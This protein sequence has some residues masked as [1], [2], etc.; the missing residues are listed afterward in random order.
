M[1]EETASVQTTADIPFR[2]RAAGFENDVFDTP[3]GGG[4]KTMAEAPT[5][6]DLERMLEA[7][8]AIKRHALNAGAQGELPVPLALS[9]IVRLCI[10]AGAK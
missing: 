8:R 4:K 10:D 5:T 1:K 7:L 6:A 3:I 2:L 9:R